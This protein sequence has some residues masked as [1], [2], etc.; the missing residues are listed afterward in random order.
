MNPITEQNNFPAA[1]ERLFY[2]NPKL[3]SSVVSHFTQ[4]EKDAVGCSRMLLAVLHLSTTSSLLAAPTERFVWISCQLGKSLKDKIRPISWLS[5]FSVS[6]IHP[7]MQSI[8]IEH[9]LEP[10]TVV[11]T[12]DITVNQNK[13]RRC[14]RTGKI[15]IK[16]LTHI[17]HTLWK[18]YKDR[19]LVPG[20]P[21]RKS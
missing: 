5:L 12:G 14:Q 2:V 19:Y 21:I 8:F 18:V 17:K 4:N 7:I 1:P 9:L 6:C 10:G 3:L 16:R 20:G 11:R 13:D 15:L